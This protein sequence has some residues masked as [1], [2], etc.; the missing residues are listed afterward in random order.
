[1]EILIWRENTKVRTRISS[2]SEREEINNF[3]N[4]GAS[5]GD[6]ASDLEQAFP[7]D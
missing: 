2:F 3:T 1:M 5:L 7:T 4:P 6:R